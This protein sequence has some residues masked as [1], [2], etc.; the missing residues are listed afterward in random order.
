MPDGLVIALMLLGPVAILGFMLWQ[1][2][3]KSG[4]PS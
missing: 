4:G 3:A 1:R 2:K